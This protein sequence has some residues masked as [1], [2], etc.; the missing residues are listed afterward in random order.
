M[1][2]LECPKWLQR[3][4]VFNLAFTIVVILW[5]ALVR[6]THSGAGC[7][8]HWPLC[9]GEVVPLDPGIETFIEFTHRV[10]SGLAFITVLVAWIACMRLAAPGSPLRRYSFLGFLFILIE[11]L[12]GAGIVIFGLVEDNDSVMRASVIAVHLANTLVL[13]T[14]LTL[15]TLFACSGR[16]PK[17]NL[18]FQ[19]WKPALFFGGFGFILI[20]I[21]AFGAIAALGNTLFP[22]TSIVDGMTSPASVGAHFLER[23]KVIHPLLA[24]FGCISLISIVQLKQ[25]AIVTEADDKQTNLWRLSGT[26]LTALVLINLVLGAFDVLL[27][28]PIWLSTL[29][30]LFADLIWIAFV[31][32][33]FESADQLTP[34]SEQSSVA[35]KT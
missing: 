31:W 28:A 8:D 10:T 17:L 24:I 21:A 35:L 34:G 9:N 18:L 2:K 27:L 16:R 30:L 6:K 15:T 4:T 19:N 23:L 32:Y 26:Y 29:H 14:F 22:A 25:S 11:A 20:L 5:G 7:G 13:L 33:A 1:P 12:I 3:L